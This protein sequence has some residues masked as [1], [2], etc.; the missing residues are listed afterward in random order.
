MSTFTVAL[1]I[2]FA[3]RP[4]LT[5]IA[6]LQKKIKDQALVLKKADIKLGQVLKAEAQ[7]SNF[8]DQ[9]PLYDSSVPSSYEYFG[10]SKRLEI[11]ASENQVQ[12][13]Y[14]KLPGSLVIGATTDKGL[15]EMK[16]TVIAKADGNGIVTI[17]VRFTVEGGQSQVLGFLRDVAG[18]DYVASIG[19]IRIVKQ[20]EGGTKVSTLSLDGTAVYYSLALRK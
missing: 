12:L 20:Q 9:L 5:N 7:L 10:I 15:T 19:D 17:P 18:I 11:L 8:K 3:V 14:L 13:K 6:S 2:L 16:G 1:L 4:T